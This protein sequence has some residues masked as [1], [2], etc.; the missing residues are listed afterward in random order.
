[1]VGDSPR[2]RLG[3]ALAAGRVV[4][5]PRQLPR[6]LDRLRAAARE[7]DVVEPRRRKLRQA[8]GELHRGGV[9]H[10]PRGR[11]RELC[12]LRCGGRGELF[13]VRIAQ[14]GAEQG[15]KGVE[16][17]V[18]ARIEDVR[19]L[20]SL[21]HEQLL[22]PGAE[23]AVAG[24]VHEEVLACGFLQFKDRI[25]L[26]A[27]FGRGGRDHAHGDHVA[28]GKARLICASAAS[29]QRELTTFPRV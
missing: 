10:A 9:G 16:V 20:A 18:A 15:R 25:H 5:Q 13:A 6:G 27:R 24:E 29:G 22:A 8:V 17:T 4:V 12:H 3:A 1:M 21:Q 28:V 26:S 14:L 11:E 7:E 19:P 23:R 2:D